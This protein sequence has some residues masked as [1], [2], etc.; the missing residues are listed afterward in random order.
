MAK[1]KIALLSNVTADM[2]AQ[3]LRREYEVYIPDGFD[4]WI[5]DVLNTASGLYT[6]SPEAVIVLNRVQKP[7]QR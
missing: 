3:K 5:S 6:S 1:R 7:P 4:M 2:V